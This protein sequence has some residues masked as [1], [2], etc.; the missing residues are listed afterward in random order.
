MGF[1]Q[2]ALVL[3][4]FFCSLVAG[5]LFAFAVVVM[6]GIKRLEDREFIRSF[7]VMDG[8]IQNNQ[9]VFMLIWVGSILFLLIASVLGFPQLD[10]VGWYLLFFATLIYFLGVH[11]PTVLINVPLNNQLQAQD[12]TSLNG[13]TQGEIRDNFEKRW[14]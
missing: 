1:M 11:L 12:V 5:F 6:P 2:A 9:P 14:N 13:Q 4:T 10:G 7:Q 8:V 3:A